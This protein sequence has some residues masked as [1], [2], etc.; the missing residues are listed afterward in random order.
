MYIY[1]DMCACI[2]THTFSCKQ[3]GAA[4][5]ALGERSGVHQMGCPEAPEILH[6]QEEGGNVG[7]WF[8]LKLPRH[9]HLLRQLNEHR[10]RV[11]P[12]RRHTGTLTRTGYMSCFWLYSPS[13]SWLSRTVRRKSDRRPHQ[14]ALF[15]IDHRLVIHAHSRYNTTDV[16]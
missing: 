16:M 3:V 11:T 10:S 8:V 14:D 9:A 1:T 12:T 6:N 4:R 15:S 2:H 13:N 7:C 5:E